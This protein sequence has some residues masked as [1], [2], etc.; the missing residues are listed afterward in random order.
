MDLVKLQRR[1]RNTF[2]TLWHEAK[3]Y[4]SA[5]ACRSLDGE[6]MKAL[7]KRNKEGWEELENKIQKS[8]KDSD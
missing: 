4:F 7:M 1:R 2:A 6:D 3:A 5:H 8:N